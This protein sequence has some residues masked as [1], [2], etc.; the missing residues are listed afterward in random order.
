MGAGQDPPV[1]PTSPV[2]PG[3]ADE[4]SR[5]AA[6]ASTC[7]RCRLAATRTNVVF[8]T[9]SPSAGLMFVGEGQGNKRTA[10]GCPSWADRGSCL[11][12]SSWKRWV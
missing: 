5:V 2:E 9:G 8:G 6:E 7:T 3:K 12:A 10:R 4:L 11:T 1:G